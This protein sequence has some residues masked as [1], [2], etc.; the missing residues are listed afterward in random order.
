[1][2]PER[3]GAQVR[4]I[5]EA[6]AG[7][8]PSER[9]IQRHFARAGLNLRPNG[10]APDVF[11]RF[12]AAASNDLWTGDA[13]HGLAVANHKTYLL[14]FIDD[15]SRLLS[16]YRWTYAEDTVRLE[17]ALR[18]GLQARGVPKAIYVDNGSAFASNQLLRACAVLGVQLVHSTVRRPEGRGKIE[19]FFRTVRDQFLVELATT[20]VAGLDELNRLFTAWVET[21]YHRRAHSETGEAPLDRFDTAGLIMPETGQLREAFL[22]SES[23]TVTKT[24]TVSLH[25]NVYQV[26]AVLVGRNVE[27][28]FDPFDLTDIEVRLDDRPMG[29]AVPYRIDRHS[30]PAARP[31][32][33]T[34]P[35]ESTGIDYLRLVEHQ[36]DHNVAKAGRIP[37]TQ[38]PLPDELVWQ[39]K[40]TNQGEQQ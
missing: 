9:T 19:R 38:L 16:G 34:E 18:S 15:H 22:W 25:S 35:V 29:A 8:S 27:L 21:V 23:R 11:G 31:D 3:T 24:A 4:R 26:D 7:W 13:M 2:N 10:T 32:P 40:N 36:R 1:G 17:A 33:V 20:P 6:E 12:E 39:A 5:I 28:V 30:H 37:Y 14:A